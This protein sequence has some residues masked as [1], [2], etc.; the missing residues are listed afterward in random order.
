MIKECN[1][2][3]VLHAISATCRRGQQHPST[4]AHQFPLT[5]MSVLWQWVREGRTHAGI[6]CDGGKHSS[7][8]SRRKEKSLPPF[9]QE[10]RYDFSKMPCY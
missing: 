6:A 1:K 7:Q 4:T 10:L 2:L 5:S 9:Q 3:K 8:P